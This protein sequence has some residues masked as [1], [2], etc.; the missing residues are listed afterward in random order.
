MSNGH[1][2]L[3]FSAPYATFFQQTCDNSESC[4]AML[5]VKHSW[6][7]FTCSGNEFYHCK[8]IPYTSDW[9]KYFI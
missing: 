9:V 2:V 6:T 5:K 8:I 1:T 4:C 3:K 7:N